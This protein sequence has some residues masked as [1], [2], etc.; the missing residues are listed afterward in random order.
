MN[1][2]FLLEPARF[3]TSL[4][5]TAE[6]MH[7]T[8]TAFRLNWWYKKE[9]EFHAVNIKFVQEKVNYLNINFKLLKTEGAQAFLNVLKMKLGRV[10]SDT[11]YAQTLNT[12][13]L[14]LTEKSN[15]LFGEGREKGH[16][17]KNYFGD[18]VLCVLGEVTIIRSCELAMK[19]KLIAKPF[20]WQTS[21]CV[22]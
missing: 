9:I 18:T 16:L 21:I 10:W 17:Q 3:I 1:L 5:W 8:R 19:L 22:T 11:V 7:G 12:P 15:P 14:R 2:C 4:D 6:Q 20:S 13:L